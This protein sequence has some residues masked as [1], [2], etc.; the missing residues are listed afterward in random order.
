MLS[1][2]RALTPS[3]HQQRLTTWRWG[4]QQKTHSP[5]RRGRQGELSYNNINLR[6]QHD[7]CNAEKLSISKKVENVPYYLYRKF[8]H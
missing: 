6:D 1:L 3:F 4:D 2:E 7:P 8:F 5:R